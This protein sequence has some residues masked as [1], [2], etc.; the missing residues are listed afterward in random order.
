MSTGSDMLYQK[1]LNDIYVGYQIKSVT[2]DP[3]VP[4][5]FVL[6]LHDTIMYIFLLHNPS[7]NKS[8]TNV[9]TAWFDVLLSCR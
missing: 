6:L 7:F 2:Y 9:V 1:M 3:N 4:K 8:Y 5:C